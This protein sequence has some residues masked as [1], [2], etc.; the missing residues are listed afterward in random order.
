MAALKV[1]QDQLQEVVDKLASLDEAL[2]TAKAKKA[3]L[4]ADVQLCEDK[5]HRATQVTA[6]AG[7]FRSD[8][9]RRERCRHVAAAVWG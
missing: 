9:S 2:A 6:A 4:A 5:L 7:S 3:Q 8:A 1:K